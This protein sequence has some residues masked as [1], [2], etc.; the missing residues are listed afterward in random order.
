MYQDH[1][2]YLWISSINGLYQYDGHTFRQFRSDPTRPD[3]FSEDFVKQFI[4]D[5]E[6]NGLAITDNGQLY[7][8]PPEEMFFRK[9]SL[10]LTETGTGSIQVRQVA[11]DANGQILVIVSG[12]GLL[13]LDLNSGKLTVPSGLEKISPMVKIM[14][15]DPE[16]GDLWFIAGS[17]LYVLPGTR[18]AQR[19][20][21]VREVTEIGTTRLNDLMVDRTGKVWMAG[22]DD[23]VIC[24]DPIQKSNRSY[25]YQQSRLS[26]FAGAPNRVNTLSEDLEGY[27]WIGTNYTGI[28][29]LDPLSGKMAYLSYDRNDQESLSSNTITDI[30]CDRSG[31]LCRN[32]GEGTE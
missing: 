28:I 23:L 2:G 20:D 5:S 16:N 10:S 8:L 29:R 31:I 12:Q 32:M 15:T 24:F 6:G 1:T 30:F 27:I 17:T 21:F 19:Q 11:A 25:S 4:E 7:I 3:G 22:Y 14:T 9:V 13:Q 26:D 18:T